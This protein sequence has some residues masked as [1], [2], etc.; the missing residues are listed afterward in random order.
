[1]RLLQQFTKMKDEI[2]NLLRKLSLS[3]KITILLLSVMVGGTVVLIVGLSSGET[4]VKLGPAGDAKSVEEMK[5]L[6]ERSG[7]PYRPGAE[8]GVLEVAGSHAA[9]AR[10][11]VAESGIA[12]AK[13][14]NFD[15]LFGEGSFLDT[16]SRIDQRLLESRKRTIEESI[17][18]SPNIRDARVVIQRGPEPIYATQPTGA[19]S[20]SVAVALRGGVEALTRSEAAT[21]RNLVSGAFRIPGQN[22][23]VTDDKLRS[24]P[25]LESSGAGI[26][27]EDDRTRK[28]VQT[29]VEGLLSRM[30]RP[31]EF[32]VGVL[33]DF[34]SRRTQRI[35][36]VYDP[37]KVATAEKSS[38]KETETTK[39]G[40]GA[41]VGVEPNVAA[42]G[43]GTAQPVPAVDTT[44]RDKKETVFENRFTLLKEQTDVPAGELKGLSVN[45][46]LD[47]AAVRRVLQAE[48]WTRVGADRRQA[49]KVES[50]SDIAN[51]TVDSRLGTA[52][53]DAAIEAYRAIQTRFLQDQLP[54]SLEKARV[55]V[56]VVMFP[57]PQM[58]VEL[59]ASE[60]FWSWSRE[61]WADL[62]LAGVAVVG[63]FVVYQMFRRALPQP[64]DV[65]PLDETQL[66]EE[67]RAADAEVESLEKRL[68][69]APAAASAPAAA[70]KTGDPEVDAML[71]AVHDVVAISKESPETAA[72]VV[73]LWM[74]QDGERR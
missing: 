74:L 5:G 51:F 43:L 37:E 39:R 42:G 66:I 70:E 34:S 71:V 24:Y 12:S 9:Q 65:P 23:Q 28:I 29:T 46:V 10:W 4:Y 48:E 67:G 62:L 30:Y 22:I 45:V 44:S 38:F 15:W 25:H 53:L 69:N 60:R 47:R 72:G 8:G 17:R 14:S 56:S 2:L 64:L 73:K 54:G 33:A 32:V 13:G 61:H 35:H 11:L 31:A 3:Q 36:E 50:P 52:N 59:A 57:Q 7:I 58:P 68:A 40:S 27:E 21:I 19:E 55:N 20:A 49:E 18:W 26:T 6:L 16:E 63:V 1:M 41:P